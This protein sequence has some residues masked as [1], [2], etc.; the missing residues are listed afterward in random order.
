MA[1]PVQ[2]NPVVGHSLYTQAY[3]EATKA[4]PPTSDPLTWVRTVTATQS[5]DSFAAKTDASWFDPGSLK[6]LRIKLV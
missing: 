1:T 6:W 3:A 4:R 5:L 2:N